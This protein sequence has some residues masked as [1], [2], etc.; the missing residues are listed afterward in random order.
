[1]RTSAP[2]LPP[3][4]RDPP[5]AGNADTAPA[6]PAECCERPRRGVGFQRRAGKPEGELLAAGF[7]AGASWRVMTAGVIGANIGAGLV[8]MLGGP[9][10][11]GLVIWALAFSVHLA[12]AGGAGTPPARPKAK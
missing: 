7:I 4:R 1:M 6:P 2:I 3:P 8:I 10:V 11:L 12:R 5:Q 9:L